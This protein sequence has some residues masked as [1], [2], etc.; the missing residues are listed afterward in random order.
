MARKPG[1]IIARGQSAWLVRIYQGR[2]PQTGTRKHEDPFNAAWVA[3]PARTLWPAM[4]VAFI[5]ALE[6][7]VLKIAAIESRRSAVDET[8]L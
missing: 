1:Q 4:L 2:D 3:I 6:A 5:P 8:L 7:A